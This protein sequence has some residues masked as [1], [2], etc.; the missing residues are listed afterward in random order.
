MTLTP[1]NCGPAQ[2]RKLPS[3]II[4]LGALVLVVIMSIALVRI[5]GERTIWPKTLL[6]PTLDFKEA[7]AVDTTTVDMRA[8]L[9]GKDAA[10][11]EIHKFTKGE[12]SAGFDVPADGHVLAQCPDDDRAG[13][14]EAALGINPDHNQRFW[15]Y[16]YSGNE[17]TNKAAGKT[18]RDLFDGKFW[19]SKK[20][21]AMSPTLSALHEHV[22]SLRNA[23]VYIMTDD[24][25]FFGCYDADHDRIKDLD[26][27]TNRNSRRTPDETDSFDA[28]TDDD[29]IIDG[30]EVER[31]TDALRVDTDGDLLQDGTEIGLTQ[32][33]AETNISTFIPDSDPSTT[34]NP[35]VPDEDGDGSPDGVE[36]SNKDGKRDIQETSPLDGDSDDD[37]LSDGYE[38]T[39]SQ[40]NPVNP[41]T[42]ADGIQDG[43][44]LSAVICVSPPVTLKGK[45]DPRI[46]GSVLFSQSTPVPPVLTINSPQNTANIVGTTVDVSYAPS[47]DLSAVDHVHLGIDDPL[48]PARDLDFDGSYQFTGVT[49]GAHVLYAYLARADHSKVEGTDVFV[50]FTTTLTPVNQTPVVNAGVDQTITLP[51]SVIL[52]G[53]VT[54]DGLPQGTV[55]T[56]WTTFSGPGTVTFGDVAAIDTTVTFSMDG[57]YVLRLSASDSI[58]AGTDD[59]TI[60]VNSNGSAPLCATPDTN[61]AIFVPDAVPTTSTDAIIA[62]T[63]TGGAFDGEEDINHNGQVDAGETDPHIPEDDVNAPGRPIC[64]NGT[65]ERAEQ[66]DD[67]NLTSGDGCQADCIIPGCGDGTPDPG[68][69]CDDGNTSNTDACTISCTL[70]SC[71]DGF[72]RAGIEECDDG[73]TINTD[74]CTNACTTPRCGDNIL[75]SGEGCDDGNAS[76]LDACN[77]ICQPTTCGDGLVQSPNGQGA[78]ETCDDGAQNGQPLQCDLSCTGGTSATCGNGI[79]EQGEEC[80]DGNTSNTDAC[81]T[82]CIAATCGDGSIRS[83]IEVCDDGNASNT[84]SC[85]NA[86]QVAQCG[87]SFMQTGEQ[88]DDGNMSN[89]DGCVGSCILAAC[90]DGFI[91]T[92]TEECDDGNITNGDGCDAICQEEVST[93]TVTL[94]GPVAGDLLTPATGVKLAGINFTETAPSGN[95]RIDELFI[96]ITGQD[97]GGSLCGGDSASDQ[98]SEVT[99]NA[100]LSDGTTSIIGSIVFTSACPGIVGDVSSAVYRFANITVSDSD[101]WDLLLDLTENGWQNHPRNGNSFQAEICSSQAGT[102]AM[103]DFTPIALG[104]PRSDFNLSATDVTAAVPALVNPEGILT[105]QTQSIQRPTLHI[106]Q[107]AGG[108]NPII[109]LGNPTGT[110]LL[111]FSATSQS[112]DTLHL[113]GFT[114]E[115]LQGSLTDMQNYTLAA[116]E[117]GNG[118]Y[119][120]VLMSGIS[121]SAGLLT[122]TLGSTPYTLL[123][124][125]T[126]PLEIRGDVPTTLSGDPWQLRFALS[127]PDYIR[128]STEDGSITLAGIATNGTCNVSPCHILATTAASQIFTIVHQGNLFV[129]KSTFPTPSRQLLGG[130]LGA[131]IL[132]LD[133]RAQHEDIELTKLVFRDTANT[134]RQSL[135]SLE[136]YRIGQSTPFAIAT[137][138]ACAGIP[139]NA[140]CASL[141]SQELV[142]PNGQTATIFIRPRIRNDVNGGVSGEVIQMQIPP[143]QAR[144]VSTT[145]TIATNDGDTRAEGEIFR[146]TGIPGPDVSI[147]GL[148]NDVVFAKFSDV[149]VAD[150]NAGLGL[151]AGPGLQLAAFSFSAAPHTNTL[152]GLNQSTINGIIF[153]ITSNN[154][155]FNSDFNLFNAADP[156]VKADCTSSGTQ[157]NFTITCLD[158]PALDTTLD[159]GGSITLNLEADIADLK[160]NDNVSASVTISLINFTSRTRTTF[161][162]ANSHIDWSDDESVFRWMDHTGGLGLFY[163]IN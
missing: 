10:N 87:D 61:L 34:T 97:V 81:L 78:Y 39:T 32:G 60:T 134:P 53:T 64:G 56:T 74:D 125:Q 49:A 102:S 30:D 157:G 109:L 6:I 20:E 149:S 140:Y 3:G 163:Q 126:V 11:I 138:A 71:G 51:S 13:T 70:S 46:A 86:C 119:E 150:P 79:V 161:G 114:F 16:V 47:G 153:N 133:L 31:T 43:T 90:G 118:T 88:C 17:E 21:L 59:V 124:S 92:A 131:E 91:Q 41:D 37:G 58:L 111:R 147:A 121:P 162:V 100:R 63:D 14:I 29:G 143:L 26:E 142:V 33:H 112:P 154:I 65:L 15:L 158:S 160:I 144:G 66:C 52:D 89:A 36:D 105:T 9:I 1:E 69:Q 57:V 93:L 28:D 122:F 80:D 48:A 101:T 27:D 50:S 127:T 68:E 110:S 18:G 19:I 159:A 25:Q 136:I 139:V 129:T 116:D 75:Q 4:T 45:N 135:E 83:G 35:L 113:N 128:A 76:T 54:D 24:V 156:S 120:R 85:T 96:A 103:C 146:G 84:D 73:N 117:D 98:I 7:A 22:G 145:N 94:T 104:G 108:A 44:E 67:G 141:S 155:L 77:A 132:R 42:D 2:K 106:L 5:F 148:A 40:T 72:V 123:P 152:N 95:I 82:S 8:R 55:T 107:Q 115:A 130:E 12:G 23:M 137:V 151:A 38:V 62:D 99:T